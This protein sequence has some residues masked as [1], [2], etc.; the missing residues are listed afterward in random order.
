MP[1]LHCS[2]VCR[3]V[4]LLSSFSLQLVD[5]TVA[6]PLAAP[7]VETIASDFRFPPSSSLRIHFDCYPCFFCQRVTILEV[8][9]S[10]H[11]FWILDLS[12]ART[13]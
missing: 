8:V 10:I 12:L 3:E 13:P 11:V 1:A 2:V 4:R 5:D 9:I 6:V 7:L